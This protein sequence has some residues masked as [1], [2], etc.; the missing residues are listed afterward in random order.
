[1]QHSDFA[2]FPLKSKVFE[3]SSTEI[4]IGSPFGG[5]IYI[6]VPTGSNFGLINITIENAVRGSLF[7]T[8]SF[9]Q[10]SLNDW[11]ESI[12][13][14]NTPWVDIISDKFM[15]SLPTPYVDYTKQV[16]CKISPQD[17]NQD[18]TFNSQSDNLTIHI[19][20]DNCL[21]GSLIIEYPNGSNEEFSCYR[22]Y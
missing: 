5:P 13:Q 21:S 14:A 11:N 9:N 1:M 19:T 10:T 18:C 4:T 7:S 6:E 15:V 3:I 22:Y 17:A 20:R 2:G 16:Y 12:I 8:R